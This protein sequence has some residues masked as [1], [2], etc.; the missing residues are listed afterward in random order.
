[1]WQT[2]KQELYNNN[3]LASGICNAKVDDRE[4]FQVIFKEKHKRYQDLSEASYQLDSSYT[5]RLQGI[6]RRRAED[7]LGKC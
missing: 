5:L 1:M 2:K 6:R 4:L 7:S 3:H